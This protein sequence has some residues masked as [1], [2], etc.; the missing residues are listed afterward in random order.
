[1]RQMVSPEQWRS[2]ASAKKRYRLAGKLSV[3]D[4]AVK[5]RAEFEIVTAMPIVRSEKQVR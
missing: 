3:V 4:K 5:V 2:L 1:M